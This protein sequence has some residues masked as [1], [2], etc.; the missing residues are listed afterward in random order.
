MTPFFCLFVLSGI[1]QGAHSDNCPAATISYLGLQ[2]ELRVFLKYLE[3]GCVLEPLDM[4]K[5]LTSARKI[6][7]ADCPRPTWSVSW[8]CFSSWSGG[9]SPHPGSTVLS[10]AQCLHHSE[11]VILDY[12]L[13][14]PAT[15]QLPAITMY[16]QSYGQMQWSRASSSVLTFRDH[17][18]VKHHLWISLSSLSN[19]QNTS[20]TPVCLLTG[21]ISAYLSCL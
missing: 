9:L 2:Q 10:L 21:T 3:N 17:H 14:V 12:F 20:Q 15:S 13:L 4:C 6:D 5:R 11:T 19:L 8:R 18:S 16:T 7:P 1:G